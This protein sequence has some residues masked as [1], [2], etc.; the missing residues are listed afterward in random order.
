[1]IDNITKLP[2]RKLKL[3]KK[4]PELIVNDMT[5]DDGEVFIF[6][7]FGEDSIAFEIDLIPNVVAAAMDRYR[8]VKERT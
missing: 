6:I 1:M 7:E 4:P 2:K 5:D 3:K 8:Q